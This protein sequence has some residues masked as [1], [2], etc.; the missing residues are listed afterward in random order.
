MKPILIV[1]SAPSGAGKSTLCDRLLQDYPELTYSVS[2]TT[3]EP[4]GAEEDGIDYHFMT[5]ERFEALVA[6]EAFLEYARVHDNYYGTLLAPL[7]QA[8]ADGLSVVMDIDVKGAALVRENLAALAADDPLRNGFVDIFIL[9]P[10]IEV[11]EERLVGRG[12]DTPETIE[13]RLG[14]AAGEMARA[15]E[16]CYRVVNNELEIAYR[17]LCAILEVAGAIKG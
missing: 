7:R 11:L 5:K 3:R 1:I 17:E 4:R 2:C 12:E 13:R 10:S 8:L 6:A 14:N 9:P 15:A 16:F